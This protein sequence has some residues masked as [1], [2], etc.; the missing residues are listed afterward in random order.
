MNRTPPTWAVRTAAD[1]KALADGY[2]WDE[3]QAERIIRFVRAYVVPK[4][5]AGEFALFEW[6]ER[7]LRSL[8][9]WR[10]PDGGRRFTKALLH[11][12]KKNG[13]TLLVS[14]IAAYELY[15]AG[16]A[17]PLVISASTT[18]KNATQVYEQ[19]KA[20]VAKQ[21]KLR[22]LAKF[23]ESEKLIRVA[24]RDGEYWSMSSDAPGAEG[25]NISCGIVDEA[26][27]HRSPTLYRTL[28]FGT[29]G[30]DSGLLVIIST[31]GN[32]LTH[33]Y[34][35]LVTRARALL[36]GNDLDP[37]F[38]AEVY[39]PGPADDLDEP[40]TWKKANPSLDLYPGF[41]TER[42][43]LAWEAAKP[44][45]GDRLNFL[46]YRMNVFTRA[47]DEAY[48]DLVRWDLCRKP[49]PLE[50]E[51]RSFPLYLGLDLSQTTD[52]SS[53]SAVWALPEKRWFVRSWAWVAAE[54]VRKREAS[55][56]PKYREF[57]ADGW[58][59]ETPGSMI[60]CEPIRRK[61]LDFRDRY[62][63]K[64]MVFDP[65]SA[66]VFSKEIE[67][68]GIEVF[69]MPQNYKHFNEPTKEFQ[70]AVLA[71]KVDH[72]GNTWLRYCFN[73]VRVETDSYGNVRPVR[74]K[75]V[76][77]IDG[78][79]STLMPFAKAWA[80]SADVKPKKS[81]YEGKGLMILGG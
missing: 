59:V 51:L 55:N 19:M 61:I 62:Q 58:M 16:V 5:V 75:S 79:V 13:K 66:V 47:E 81:V 11:V 14:I 42:F 33:F 21:K 23:T 20:V 74:A 37:T 38:Y 35:S 15:A 28:E 24:S 22:D 69:R 26:H 73:S 76:D 48:I 60:D 29:S 68:E 77:H 7:M 18:K 1:R 8:Y 53:L 63:V 72:D 41:T 45:T 34:Y 36:A 12:A 39:E 70:S 50:S 44:S 67:G 6:Q 71:G 25:W 56:L 30:R 40:R 80:D 52:P 49:A 65:N 64:C 17:S 57:I 32:D 46:R 3:D 31:A 9:G 27:A 4:Y 2:Y 43:R 78:A 54:G 10:R